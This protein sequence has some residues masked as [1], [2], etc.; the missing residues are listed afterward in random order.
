ML[1]ERKLFTGIVE[2]NTGFKNG[3]TEKKYNIMPICADI[4]MLA[5][6]VVCGDTSTSSVRRRRA[7]LWQH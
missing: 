3:L 2:I 4:N 5:Y 7:V 6:R 1:L